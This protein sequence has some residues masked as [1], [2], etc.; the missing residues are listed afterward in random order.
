ML[1]VDVRLG[2]RE[3]ARATDAAEARE[4]AYEASLREDLG[5]E[6]TLPRGMPE[7]RL[8]TDQI[9][10]MADVNTPIAVGNKGY[11]MLLRMGWGGGGLGPKQSGQACPFKCRVRVWVFGVDLTC[12]IPPLPSTGITE[13]VRGGIDRWDRAGG[14]GR[15]EQDEKM[16]NEDNLER[17]KLA[18]EVEETDADRV[19][20]EVHSS[21]PNPTQHPLRSL[22]RTLTRG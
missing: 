17:R 5:A 10:G 21:L 19:K 9:E 20:R 13:P 15:Q 6:W 1:V 3:T 2:G 12:S 4:H 16:T 7:Q 11:Q 18:Q 8:R 22:T 14:V